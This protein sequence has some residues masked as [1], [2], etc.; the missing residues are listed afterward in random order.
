MGQRFDPRDLDAAGQATVRPNE[1]VPISPDIAALL[2]DR[3]DPAA[4]A[5]NVN[6]RLM[7]RQIYNSRRDRDKFFNT[8]LLSEP[9]W[10]MM[11]AAYCLPTA[12]RPLTVSG[13][14]Q[15]A[16]CPMTTALRW[17]EC[18]RVEGLIEKCNDPFDKRVIF[19]RLTPT[20]LKQIE[21]YLMHLAVRHP[22]PKLD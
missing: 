22:P 2:S 15:A 18:M 4:G 7:A 19:V 20:G 1:A 8:D 10:D 12:Y 3:P 14:A 11:L 21:A 17:I 9:A 5:Q 13:L 16:A 6:F